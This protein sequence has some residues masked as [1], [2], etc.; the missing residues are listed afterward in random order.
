MLEEILGARCLAFFDHFFDG[1]YVVDRDRQIVF[2][3]RSA[4]LISGYSREDVLGKS[5]ADNLLRHVT[6]DGEALC[7]SGCPLKATMDDGVPRSAEVYLH[8]KHGHRVPVFVRANPLHDDAGNIIGAVEIFADNS[9]HEAVFRQLKDMERSLYQDALTGIGN[10]KFADIRLSELMGAYRDHGQVFGVL[11]ADIDRFKNIN[12]TYGHAI[13]DKVIALVARTL[14]N[15][16]RPTDRVCR[17]GGEEF[18]CLLPSIDSEDIAQIAERVRMLVERAW[19][20]TSSGAL[21]VTISVGGALARP[22]DGAVS[23]VERADRSMYLAKQAGRNRVVIS[24]E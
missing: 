2:W 6:Q 23:L 8:H 22:S 20:D 7:L 3:N 21:R 19:L 18:V 4:E 16:L 1:V 5:C 14:Q 17:Y 9:R 10:R 12:D 24:E 11:F 15:G 13:G